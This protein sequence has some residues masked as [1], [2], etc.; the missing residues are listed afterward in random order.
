M[1]GSHGGD[2]GPHLPWEAKVPLP[3]V[4]PGEN[5]ETEAQA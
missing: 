3:I 2:K 4:Q 1:Q 5:E